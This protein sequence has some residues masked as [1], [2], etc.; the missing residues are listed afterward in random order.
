MYFPKREL[1]SFLVVLA[2]P[3]ASMIGLLA[4]ICLSVSLK[5][6]PSEPPASVRRREEDAGLDGSST[7][8]KYRKMN[9]ADT[10]FPAPLY[11]QHLRLVEGELG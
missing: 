3:N 4:K 11:G 10:V 1:L 2:L 6:S 8:A 5:F 9:L 7:E